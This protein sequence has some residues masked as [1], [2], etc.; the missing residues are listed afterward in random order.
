M[1]P[2]RDAKPLSYIQIFKISQFTWRPSEHS[3]RIC[4]DDYLVTLGLGRMCLYKDVVQK[5]PKE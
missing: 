1:V 2:N 5:N 4:K 3:F